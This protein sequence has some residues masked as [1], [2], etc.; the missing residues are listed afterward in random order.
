MGLKVFFGLILL[1]SV[2]LSQA[3]PLWENE[4]S[5]DN[6]LNPFSQEQK[7]SEDL[8]E[9]ELLASLG[10]EGAHGGDPYALEF[11]ALGKVL[12]DELRADGINL[13][14]FSA[15]LN[16]VLVYSAE[17]ERVILNGVEVAAINKNNVI[18][19]NATR[20]RQSNLTEKLS[21]VLH[22]Y[23]GIM[24][25]ERD[26]YT[27]SKNIR[28]QIQGIA[29]RMIATGR[30]PAQYYG[31]C[32]ASLGLASTDSECEGG[33]E[34]QRAANCA[35]QQAMVRCN[36]EKNSECRYVGTFVEKKLSKKVLGLITCKVTGIAK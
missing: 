8:S 32:E 12:V 23:L 21:L 15:K 30:S 4:P 9:E 31:M 13:K 18:L 14:K 10:N 25:V 7:T 26:V 17:K 11:V 5:G 20:W 27:V 19:I 2:S 29:A 34:V 1:L 6:V 33:A 24:N 36:S 22:E 35:Q 28:S 16:T 3:A